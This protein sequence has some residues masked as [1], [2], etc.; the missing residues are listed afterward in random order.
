MANLV[1]LNPSGIN[2]QIKCDADGLLYFVP[3]AAATAASEA[4]TTAYAA[5]LVVKA[6]AGRLMGFCGYNSKASAQFIQVHNAAALPAD[7]AVPLI[8]L[9]VPAQ[10][11]FSW[12]AGSY[13]YPFS[14]GIVVCNSSTGP[15]KTI[16]SAD[17]WFNVLYG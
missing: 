17:C 16:G 7:T 14:T 5:S 3:S 8:V 2:T 13:P 6:S 4:H 12:D 11:S 1:A 10:S 15:T 9:Y